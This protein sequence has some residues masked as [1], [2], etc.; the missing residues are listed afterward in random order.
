MKINPT[1]S[2]YY[3][4]GASSL[5][6]FLPSLF[7]IATFSKSFELHGRLS[8]LTLLLHP[9]LPFQPSGPHHSVPSISLNSQ[10]P[11]GILNCSAMALPSSPSRPHT[12]LIL[13]KLP[14]PAKLLT[15]NRQICLT[16]PLHA[17][18]QIIGYHTN[19]PSTPSISSVYSLPPSIPSR[20]LPASS[21]RL[22]KS[23][24]IRLGH[25]FAKIL[26]ITNPRS[27]VRHLVHSPNVLRVLEEQHRYPCYP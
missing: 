1:S 15:Y 7:T 20:P 24:V 13:P 12:P 22:P 5:S 18:P 10:L 21:L 26:K 9:Q 16:P 4:Q 17:I 3:V 11:P 19:P 8:Y 6:S 25:P 23:I 27:L 14:C 2:S